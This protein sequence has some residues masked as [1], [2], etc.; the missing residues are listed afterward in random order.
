MVGAVLS[1]V[2]TTSSVETAQTP[3]DSVQRKVLLPTPSPVTPD[4][5]LVGLVMLPEPE[6]K[7]QIPVPVAGLF[8]AKVAVVPQT[9]WFGPALAAVNWFTVTNTEFELAVLQPP[10]VHVLI[11]L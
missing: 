11:T 6:I 1:R 8:P 10:P 2:I 5:G 4:A 7:V 9:V 3:F